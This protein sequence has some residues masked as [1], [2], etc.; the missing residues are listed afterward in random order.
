[1][2]RDIFRNVAKV[3]GELYCN[4]IVDL[5]M[6]FFYF[7][8]LNNSSSYYHITFLL[9]YSIFLVFREQAFSLLM[10]QDGKD[11]VTVSHPI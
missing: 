8:F 5:E 1:M 10:M 6:F 2:P 4:T 7:F 11:C 3:H 9:C